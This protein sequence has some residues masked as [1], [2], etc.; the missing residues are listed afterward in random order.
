MLH[1]ELLFRG[2]TKEEL[3]EK[4]CNK[5]LIRFDENLSSECKLLLQ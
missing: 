4:I 1:G 5:S 2:K 3:I